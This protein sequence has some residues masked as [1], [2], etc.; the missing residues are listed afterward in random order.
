MM[1]PTFFIADLHLSPA[2]P[3]TC[4]HFFAWLKKVA[5]RGEAL[6]ILGDLF[7]YWAGDDDLS[8]P[9]NS[10]VA[11]AL[12]ALAQQ[13]V[14]IY[15]MHGN[16]DFLLGEAFARAS[17]ATLLPDPT[18]IDL[19]GT[20]TLL[21][22]GDVFCTDDREYAAFRETVRSL[23]WQNAFLARPL[24]ERRAVAEALRQ[25]SRQ[26]QA[27]KSATLLDVNVAEID[28]ALHHS[29]C[30]RLI[31]GHT[32]RPARHIHRVEGSSRERWVL[33]DWYGDGGYLVCE[34]GGCRLLNV[35]TAA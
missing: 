32:H 34:A 15:V 4:E 13:G 12:L 6:Y 28:Q 22:H 14:R 3:D 23:A 35:D 24:S 10:A 17:G 16:R 27:S 31:H 30:T 33:A 11:S 20:P 8:S 19:Y 21:S 26:A 1:R 2:H 25:K 5:S 7:E 18:A 9:F 29:G